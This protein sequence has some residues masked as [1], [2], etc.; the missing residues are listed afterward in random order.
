MSAIS[1]HDRFL[2]ARHFTAKLKSRE[3]KSQLAIARDYGMAPTLI[4][5][6][7]ELLKLA[8]EIQEAIGR[9]NEAEV[10]AKVKFSELFDISQIKDHAEQRRRFETMLSSHP[11]STPFA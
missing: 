2:L 1:I 6:I 5:T 4:R 7:C 10:A 8:T 3:A 9:M 11:Y